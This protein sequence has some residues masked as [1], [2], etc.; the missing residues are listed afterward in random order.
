MTIVLDLH[1]RAMDLADAALEAKRLGNEDRFIMFS[2]WALDF[3]RKAA[4]KIAG[5]FDAE[6]T[7]SV[8]L[9]S[10]ASLALDIGDHRCAEHL[11]AVALAGNPPEE[12]AEELRDLSEQVYFQRHLELRKVTLEP[13]ELQMSI[14]GKGV[15]YGIAQGNEVMDRIRNIEKMIYRTVQR[16]MGKP[17]QGPGRPSTASR[18]NYEVYMSTARAASFAVSLKIGKP[19]NKEGP[20]GKFPNMEPAVDVLNEMVACLE[21][22][23]HGDEK[24]LREKIPDE[25]YYENFIQLARQI[26]PDGNNVS[27]VGITILRGEKEQ[28]VAFRRRRE[29][30]PVFNK[31]IPEGS[32]GKEVQI[33]GTLQFADSISKDHSIKLVEKDT[34]KVH[35]VFVRESMLSDI[36]RPLYEDMVVVF[37]TKTAKGIILKD[38]KKADG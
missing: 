2:K 18:E 31:S 29:Q 35:K 27:Q 11:I 1:R 3:E 14:S 12:I 36:V 15:G 21:L 20:Q 37:G 22:V 34:G 9:R 16:K 8:L 4:E 6:P 30:I 33:T 19:E 5:D 7:R 25:T 26:A 23:S 10:A 32:K 28:S 13:E 38:I 17:F 24:G